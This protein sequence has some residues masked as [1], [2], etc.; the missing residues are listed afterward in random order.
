MATKAIYKKQT[1]KTLTDNYW[2]DP[3]ISQACLWR[4]KGKTIPSILGA[5]VY[6]IFSRTVV[7]MLLYSKDFPSLSLN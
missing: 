7:S 4:G 1:H 6:V 5:R 2:N 3:W